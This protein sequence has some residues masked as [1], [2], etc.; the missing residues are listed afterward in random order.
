MFYFWFKFQVIFNKYQT[1][2]LIFFN[3]HTYSIVML[4]DDHVYH[5]PDVTTINFE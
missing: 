4:D 1:F 3:D 2:F 5:L